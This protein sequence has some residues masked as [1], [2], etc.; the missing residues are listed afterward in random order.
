MHFVTLARRCL[1]SAIKLHQESSSFTSIALSRRRQPW[2]AHLRTIGKGVPALVLLFGAL[3]D[4]TAPASPGES[5]PIRISGSYV[6][7]AICKDGIIVASDSRGTLKNKQG[8]RIAYY[9]I[10]QKI[11]PIG[12]SLIAD[13]GFASLNDPNISFLSA[14]MLQFADSPRSHAAV[15]QLP[16]SYFQY[17][18]VA[19][20][21]PGAESAKIQTLVFAGFNE[22]K[23]LLCIYKGESNREMQCRSSGYL[24]SPNEHIAGLEG[25]EDLSFQQAARVMQETIDNYAAAVQPGSVGGPVVMRTITPSGSQ[26]RGKPPDW[27]NWNSF[28]D[29]ARDYNAGRVPFHLMPGV[30]KADLDAVI[31][32]GAAWAAVR[33][34]SSSVRSR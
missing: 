5:A 24:S 8:R 9:D 32:Q 6:I 21:T 20:P 17:V 26:W 2:C 33:Q 4:A 18:N 22:S 1:R 15:G 28:A 29:L 27:P 31:D 13:T 10:N 23:P 7:A 16:L 19:L 30:S 11:F 34:G 25:A 3:A 12:N 14:L